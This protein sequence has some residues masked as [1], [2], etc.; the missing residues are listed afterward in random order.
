[1]AENPLSSVEATKV[2]AERLER[3][4]QIARLNGDGYN[5]AWTVAHALADLASSSEAYLKALPTLVDESVEGDE[6]VQRLIQVVNELQHMLYHLEDPKFFRQ[7]L[8]PLRADWEK[9]RAV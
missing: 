6:L 2:L 3:C 7:L 9:S 5:E 4:E 8:E 1:M